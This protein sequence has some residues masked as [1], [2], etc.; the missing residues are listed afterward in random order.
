MT[1]FLKHK[2]I[3]LQSPKQCQ[4][5]LLISPGLPQTPLALLHHSLAKGKTPQSISIELLL[6]V[7][8]AVL[9]WAA[10]MV[11]TQNMLSTS[12]NPRL[13]VSLAPLAHLS[14]KSLQLLLKRHRGGLPLA[15]QSR[16]SGEAAVLPR[17]IVSEP[18]P[19]VFQV[20]QSA[21]LPRQYWKDTVFE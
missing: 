14:S 9:S 17:A 21:Q 7:S 6:A 18:S 16:R 4:L 2:C 3:C 10:H 11:T 15:R 20:Q 8:Q 12:L 5:S 19:N 1:S 13:S